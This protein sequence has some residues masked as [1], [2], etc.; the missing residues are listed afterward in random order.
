MESTGL[1][2]MRED[3]VAKVIRGATTF[4]EVLRHTPRTF[5]MRP[6]RQILAMTQ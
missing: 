6:L 4:D 1:L 3:G 5:S 2:S